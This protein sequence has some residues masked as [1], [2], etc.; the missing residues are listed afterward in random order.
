MVAQAESEVLPI[1]VEFS[2]FSWLLL[3]SRDPFL[4]MEHRTRRPNRENGRSRE[5]P[6]ARAKEADDE[7]A[8]ERRAGLGG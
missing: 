6:K 7:E 3:K 2:H 4:G 5:E 8:S 1:Q